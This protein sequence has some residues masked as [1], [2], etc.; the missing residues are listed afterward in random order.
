MRSRVYLALI[1]FSGLCALLFS[2]R[3]AHLPS[4]E[5]VEKIFIGEG[6]KIIFV[7]PESVKVPAIRGSS[8]LENGELC[9]KCHPEPS[10]EPDSTFR[11][12]HVEEFKEAQACADCHSARAPT[13]E[14]FAESEVAPVALTFS[15]KRHLGGRVPCGQC[16]MLGVHSEGFRVD[17]LVCLECHEKMKGPVGCSTCHPKWE[18]IM[19]SFHRGVDI[20][21]THGKV[22]REAMAKGE[23]RGSRKATDCNRCHVKPNFCI[24]CHGIEMPHPEGYLKRHNQ[25]VKGKPET[26]ALCHGKN[27]CLNCHKARGVLGE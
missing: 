2:C 26:C 4:P 22:E 5:E 27:P 1:S 9:G 15:H 11:T 10:L 6:E 23:G 17:M 16:H 13:K 18:E 21:K 20:V 25:E 12:T 24:D 8:I 14:M 7:N 19:P 3:S